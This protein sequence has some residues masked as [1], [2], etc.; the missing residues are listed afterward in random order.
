MRFNFFLAKTEARLQCTLSAVIFVWKQSV[1][2]FKNIYYGF[3]MLW[4]RHRP[5]E[6]VENFYLFYN[7]KKK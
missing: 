5:R 6:K 2:E 4:K 3:F 1:W 7:S